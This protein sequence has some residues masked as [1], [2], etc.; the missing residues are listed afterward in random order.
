MTRRTKQSR[1]GRGSQRTLVESLGCGEHF[2][3]VGGTAWLQPIHGLVV[4][5]SVPEHPEES[6]AFRDVQAQ[7]WGKGGKGMRRHWKTL[8]EEDGPSILKRTGLLKILVNAN[9]RSTVTHLS[10]CHP[11]IGWLYWYAEGYGKYVRTDPSAA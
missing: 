1:Q 9:M 5:G 8:R 4:D 2:L 10:I 3:G 7:L 11:M 6:G